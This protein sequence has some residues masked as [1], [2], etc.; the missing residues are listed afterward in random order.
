M[1]SPILATVSA[2][3]SAMVMLPTLAALIA[4]TSVPTSSATSAIILHQALEQIVA[5]DEIGLGIDLDDDALLALDGSAG[6]TFGGDAAG[7]LGGLRQA[8]LAQPV[9]GRFHVAVV[10]AE[11]GLAIHH[12]R[13]GRVAQLLDHLCGDV[14]HRGSPLVRSGRARARLIID[15]CRCW[16]GVADTRRRARRAE[17]HSA[18]AVSS[19]DFAI[20]L[21]TRPGNPTSSPILWAASGPSPAI[22]Q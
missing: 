2:I 6:Q 10:L 21:S 13:A 12:A 14:G 4:S 20:Q 3:A 7:L 11:R 19:F 18:S 22:C 16:T 9:D 8:L 15:V 5:R 1:F 17:A